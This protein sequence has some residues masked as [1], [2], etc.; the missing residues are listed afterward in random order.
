MNRS[1]SHL[2]G[3]LTEQASV[4]QVFG[5]Q[6][7]SSLDRIH[8]VL[9]FVVGEVTGGVE[10]YVLL[11]CVLA[12]VRCLSATRQAQCILHR[13]VLWIVAEVAVEMVLRVFFRKV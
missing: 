9:V 2:H 13:T 6:L 11:V 12:M 7:Q 8:S 1:F 4:L 10:A 5:N 3:N